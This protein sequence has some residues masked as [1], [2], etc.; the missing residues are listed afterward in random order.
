MNPLSFGGRVFLRVNLLF[1]LKNGIFEES[2]RGERG[3]LISLALIRYMDRFYHDGSSKTPRL[4]FDP[5]TGTFEI[6]GRSIPENSIEFFRPA[7]DWLDAYISTHPSGEHL[8]RIRL[9]YFN[10]SSSKCL[11]DICRRMEK[12]QQLGCQVELKWYY[13]ADDEDMQDSGLDFKEI[14]RLPMEMVRL[15]GD[16]G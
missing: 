9:E 3:G 2:R 4:C 10:T 6:T 15:D 13:E 7:L 11:V 5:H 14:L 8:L 12:L 16:E 1:K